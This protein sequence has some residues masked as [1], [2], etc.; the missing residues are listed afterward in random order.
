MYQ[1]QSDRTKQL[2]NDDT[3]GILWE[4]IWKNA[5]LDARQFVV[6][7]LRHGTRRLGRILRIQRDVDHLSVEQ[8]SVDRAA[9]RSSARS[10]AL[11]QS[12][13]RSSLLDIINRE[14]LLRHLELVPLA[15]ELQNGLA[16]DAGQNQSVQRTRDQ[17][18]LALLVDPQ[19]EDVHRAALHD[20]SL[21]THAQQLAVALLLPLVRGQDRRTV[22]G[23]QLVGSVAAGPRAHVVCVRHQLDGLE[24]RG[25]VGTR[26][27]ADRVHLAALGRMN[28]QE[29][30][31]GNTGGTDVQR[32]ALSLGNPVLIHAHQL[33]DG[34]Q[35]HI[36][37]HGLQI[38]GGIHNPQED[39]DA[40][41][42]SSYAGRSRGG[43]TCECDRRCR[44]TPSFPQNTLRHEQ[45][46]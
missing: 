39:R 34:L 32:V 5:Q 19:E 25:V 29:G 12:L 6:H 38:I 28:A 33:L 37:I 18:L 17:L 13:L 24:A 16:R 35:V 11:Q 43:G 21:R 42:T 27:R 30:V 26:R 1:T 3:P 41:S 44:D 15:R 23:A 14:L 45:H 4:R 2:V 40:Q 22:V 8:N 10:E 20:D 7:S 9:D 31:R 46:E 36:R